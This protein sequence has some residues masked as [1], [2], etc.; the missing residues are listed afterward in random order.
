MRKLKS[1]YQFC[2][3]QTGVWRTLL[4]WCHICASTLLDQQER[5][6]AAYVYVCLRLLCL[7]DL[8][9]RDTET[10]LCEVISK[11]VS[12]GEIRT[13]LR[14]PSSERSSALLSSSELIQT[15]TVNV[16]GQTEL[17]CLKMKHTRVPDHVAFTAV[18]G[19]DRNC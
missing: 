16:V 14:I 2:I 7:F 3:I 1:L 6:A 19:S 12:T 9:E 15:V 4:C 10:C 13:F 18:H 17:Q 11:N 5:D 8:R